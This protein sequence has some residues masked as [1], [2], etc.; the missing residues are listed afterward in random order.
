MI[1]PISKHS[2]RTELERELGE[3]LMKKMQQR[4]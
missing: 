4:Y 2:L 3:N 1:S